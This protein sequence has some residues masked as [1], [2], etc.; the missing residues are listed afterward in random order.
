MNPVERASIDDLDSLLHLKASV[1]GDMITHAIHQW[2]ADYPG[3]DV[4]EQDLKSKTLYVIRDHGHII[5]S[6]TV[7]EEND[8]A[9]RALTWQGK[10]ALVIH[11]LMV[12]PHHVRK[13]LASQLFAHAE[14]LAQKQGYDSI[15]VDTHPDNYRMLALIR[16]LG[17][18]EIGYIA[19]IHRI[20]F[21]K[22]LI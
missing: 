14:A 15:K 22:K 9:Y 16:K 18:R 5:A 10:Q 19:S 20:G 12:S 8:P 17:Y 11:R 2:T 3:Q 1:V 4:F 6:V 21:E 7:R 13:G